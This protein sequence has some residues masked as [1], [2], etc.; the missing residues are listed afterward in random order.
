MKIK[1][2]AVF[3][4]LLFLLISCK[5]DLGQAP[6]PDNYEQSINEWKEYRISRL[7]EPTGWL[8][9]ADL[10]WLEEG[11]NSFGSS[12]D[13]DIRFPE[14][15]IPG[16]AGTFILLDGEVTMKVADDVIITHDGSPVQEM[17]IFDGE[18]RPEVEHEDLIWFVDSRGDTHGIRI[19]N[20]D[21][22]KADR[23]DGFPFYPL[24]PAWHLQARFI[25]WPD[26]RTIPVV[27]VLGETIERESPGRVEF[28]IDGE[29]YSLDAFESASGLFLMFTDQTGRT[30][31]FQGGRYMIID[32]P[33]ENGNTIIDFNKAYNP[34]CA[35]SK[36]TTCQLPPPQNRLDVEIPAGEQ[37][38]VEWDGLD[39]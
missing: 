36:F 3:V 39:L 21:T 38:P 10:I 11:E 33:D 37:R 9:L 1:F 7:T 30:E 31:T 20:R 2:S 25:S 8:R 17:V 22:P 4:L 27:N 15:T 34:P 6:L 29:R 13:S 28:V 12:P 14:G 24:D 35:F 16:F 32:H 26:E 19:Y 5:E 18:N 23:F